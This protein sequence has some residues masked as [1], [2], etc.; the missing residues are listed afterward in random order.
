MRR[1]PQVF[2]LSAAAAALLAAGASAA[3]P[4]KLVLGDAER[5]QASARP[6]DERPVHPVGGQVDY[7]SL[8]AGF[9]AARSGHVHSGQDVFAPAG[10]PLVAV[11]DGIVA[12]A[13]SD[14]GR[15]NYVA[16]FDPARRRTY[17]Y[18]H[19]LEPAAVRQGERVSAG[20]RL[21]AVGCTG[22]CWGDHL[23][24]EVRL[25]RGA[26]GEAI[27]PLP[28]LRDWPAPEPPR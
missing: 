6:G 11:D 16:L 2:I 27:D 9:G 5:R 13:G 18:F 22:S 20:Q 10:T 1:V 15:G 25:G 7:G 14:G 3:P 23:H 4:S 24:F 21:G 26:Y 19:M 17:V 8:E 28:L 12:E